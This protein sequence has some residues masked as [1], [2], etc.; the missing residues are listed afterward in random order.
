MTLTWLTFS[1]GCFTASCCSEKGQKKRKKVE[2]THN[3]PDPVS[4]Y[5][6]LK[7]SQITVLF[8]PSVLWSSFWSSSCDVVCTLHDWSVTVGHACK[9]LYQEESSKFYDKKTT[10]NHKQDGLRISK[11]KNPELNKKCQPI[12]IS[13][14]PDIKV[15]S[16]ASSSGARYV[17]TGRDAPRFNVPAM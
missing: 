16:Q 1:Y 15:L 7:F 9:V 2:S 10:I 8:T 5:I 11:I 17:V 6:T 3:L 4:H 12:L 13:N 14:L